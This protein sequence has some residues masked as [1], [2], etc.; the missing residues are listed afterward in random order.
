VTCEAANE[1]T[2]ELFPVSEDRDERPWDDDTVNAVL[3][4]ALDDCAQEGAE[5]ACV[6][7]TPSCTFQRD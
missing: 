6:P 5:G 3:D 4:Q 7:A 2:G 1:E